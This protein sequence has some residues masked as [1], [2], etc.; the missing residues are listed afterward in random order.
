MYNNEQLETFNTYISFHSKEYVVSNDNILFISSMYLYNIGI[1]L[2]IYGLMLL[3]QNIHRRTIPYFVVQVN[4][5]K[6]Q[7]LK[8]QES[9]PLIF[10]TFTIFPAIMS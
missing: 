3:L 9:K 8:C 1:F 5:L 2:K 7:R 10:G 4:N 6:L